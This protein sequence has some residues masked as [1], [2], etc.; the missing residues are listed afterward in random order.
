MTFT[1]LVVREGQRYIN[2]VVKHAREVVTGFGF[3]SDGIWPEDKELPEELRAAPV[4]YIEI[5]P[6]EIMAK[7]GYT[8]LPDVRIP[9]GQ[10]SE[11][12]TGYHP[13]KTLRRESRLLVPDERRQKELEDYVLYV[14]TQKDREPYAKILHPFKVEKYTGQNINVFIDGD[15]VAEQEEERVKGRKPTPRTERT[16]IKHIDIRVET[17]DGARFNITYT[18][19]DTACL[20]LLAVLLETGLIKR[21]MN[22]FLD[23]EK[24]LKTVVEKYFKP[25]NPSFELDFFHIEEKIDTFTSLGI[26]S[27]RVDS[28]WDEPEYY[29]Q[30]SR[31]GEIKK[32]PKTALSRTYGSIIKEAIFYGNFLETFDYVEHIP[33]EHIQDKKWLDEFIS[34]I[35]ERFDMLTCYAARKKVG[36]KNSSNASELCNELIVS[37][38]Q[39]VDDRMHWCEKG[40]A[41]LA[42]ISAM[43]LNQ[44]DELWFRKHEV[45]FK[46]YYVEPTKICKIPFKETA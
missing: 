43:F 17:D 23:G 30:K 4:E 14:N 9:D 11:P 3:S 13:R 26:K 10:F 7:A 39:K 5:D 46:L 33:K 40:S 15:L 37:A 22:V 31:L 20:I 12:E 34:Y 21:H 38:R 44:V 28:P 32:Q 6:Q 45:S 42:A 25:W 19:M 2:A 24:K 16:N 29:K 8:P 18:D 1:S 35:K 27:I 41:S 36:L